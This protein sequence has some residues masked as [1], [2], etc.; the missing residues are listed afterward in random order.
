MHNARSDLKSSFHVVLR[1]ALFSKMSH[2]DVEL[3]AFKKHIVDSLC[4]STGTLVEKYFVAVKY[5]ADVVCY[6]SNDYKILPEIGSLNP[7]SEVF[8]RWKVFTDKNEALSYHQALT[9]M[10]LLELLPP[11]PKQ[12]IQERYV[13]SFDNSPF[14]VGSGNV[15][16]LP[17]IQYFHA[18]HVLF[19]FYDSTGA[20]C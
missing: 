20:Y 18:F 16:G 7:E 11:S 10:D 19:V 3:S 12:K 6:H 15:S 4:A 1:F 17:S 2:D 13:K 5:D 9:K 14:E 8:F